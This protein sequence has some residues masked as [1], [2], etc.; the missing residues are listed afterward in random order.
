MPPA[1]NH[2]EATLVATTERVHMHG[3]IKGK[4]HREITKTPTMPKVVKRF[5]FHIWQ[6]NSKI[7][8]IRF[9]EWDQNTVDFSPA[10]FITC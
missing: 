6:I 8:N 2:S 10:D 1:A 9:K 7:K 3:C 4:I 5:F